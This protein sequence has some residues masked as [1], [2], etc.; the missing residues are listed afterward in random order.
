LTNI[1]LDTTIIT[2]MQCKNNRKEGL[3]AII[4]ICFIQARKKPQVIKIYATIITQ[5]PIQLQGE[6]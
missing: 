1:G 4:E 6:T 3:V 5:F 2:D